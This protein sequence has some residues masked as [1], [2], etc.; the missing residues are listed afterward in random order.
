MNK[1]PTSSFI[2]HQ[3]STSN[4]QQNER[5]IRLSQSEYHAVTVSVPH[6]TKQLPKITGSNL[7][8]IPSATQSMMAGI[9]SPIITVPSQIRPSILYK[10]PAVYSSITP[11]VSV[12]DQSKKMIEQTSSPTPEQTIVVQRIISVNST[13]NKI[14]SNETDAENAPRYF[15]GH[16]HSNHEFDELNDMQ[17]ATEHAI[18]EFPQVDKSEVSFLKLEQSMEGKKW[19]KQL[20]NHKELRVCGLDIGLP[21]LSVSLNNGFEFDFLSS[22]ANVLDLKLV[23]INSNFDQTR[24][25]QKCDIGAG[26]FLNNDIID[27]G[28]NAYMQ[29]TMSLITLARRRSEINK[30]GVMSEKWDGGHHEFKRLR[31]YDTQRALING[32]RNKEIDGIYQSSVFNDLIISDP[33][34]G[35]IELERFDDLKHVF[36]FPMD[37]PELK[38]VLNASIDFFV[39]FVTYAEWIEWNFKL[40]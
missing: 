31:V 5:V 18:T 35:T 28:S 8:N 15:D 21:L 26:G 3:N 16:Q 12:K 30:I 19:K 36:L 1:K 33:E 32:F 4:Y 34:S 20:L 25:L 6:F 13:S 22:M 24:T 23:L 9:V 37:K 14:N 11:V 27:E 38:E 2:A 7:Y 17:W 39:G 29:S 10:Q 40:D